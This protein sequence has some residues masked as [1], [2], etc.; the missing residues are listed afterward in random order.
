MTMAAHSAAI[1][2]SGTYRRRPIPKTG[3][4]AAGEYVGVE[5]T[6]EFI[7]DLAHPRARRLQINDVV[8]FL[9]AAVLHRFEA[10]PHR[11]HAQQLGRLRR[12][13]RATNADAD[14]YVRV[15]LDNLLE[16]VVGKAG[17]A[18]VVRLRARDVLGP[19]VLE[20]RAKVGAVLRGDELAG[21]RRDND[22]HARLL[23]GQ[24]RL[25]C[26]HFVLERLGLDLTL[27]QLARER[28][29]LLEATDDG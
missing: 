1:A 11:R 4:L 29:D 2:R 17:E 10:G 12:A 15:R 19:K 7:E 16:A 25:Y 22:Q 13:G 18:E 6:W 28:P 3:R 20:Q 9:H 21:S 8:H 14:D 23:R 27:F 24:L 26:R 5:E